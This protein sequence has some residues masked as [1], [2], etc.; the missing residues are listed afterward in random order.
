MSDHDVWNEGY[1][2][3]FL[4]CCGRPVTAPHIIGNPY[5]EKWRHG[6]I[7]PPPMPSL[8]SPASRAMH[9]GSVLRHGERAVSSAGV[10]HFW[11]ATVRHW[12]PLTDPPTPKTTG[13]Q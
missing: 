4:Q 6:G 13:T 1:I 8:P 5:D 10:E 12:V 9:T 7:A 11:D 3:G 2:E